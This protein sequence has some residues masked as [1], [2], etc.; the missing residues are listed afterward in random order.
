LD[1]WLLGIVVMII[2]VD[3]FVDEM[4]RKR[5]LLIGL[6]DINRILVHFVSDS[7]FFN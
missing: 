1:K 7:Q 6:S 4:E 2:D 5:E 3:M